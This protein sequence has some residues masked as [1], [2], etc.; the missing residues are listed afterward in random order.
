MVLPCWDETDNGVPDFCLENELCPFHPHNPYTNDNC[1]CHV[2]G[3]I[4]WQYFDHT[5]KRWMGLAMWSTLLAMF[6]TTYGALSLSLRCMC[7]KVDK[8]H[9]IVETKR[10]RRR[11]RRIRGI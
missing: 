8:I 4:G 9:R 7:A 1:V 6:V 3:N 5:R 10:P 2:F 11:T